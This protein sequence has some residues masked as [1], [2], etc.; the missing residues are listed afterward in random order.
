MPLRP[1]GASEV[2]ILVPVPFASPVKGGGARSFG[3]RRLGLSD[4]FLVGHHGFSVPG[5]TRRPV[6]RGRLSVPLRLQRYG[7]VVPPSTSRHSS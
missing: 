3:R 4:G 2:G 5:A 6:D 1:F 7:R